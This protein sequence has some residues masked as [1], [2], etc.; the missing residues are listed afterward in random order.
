MENNYNYTNQPA[1]PQPN[2]APQNNNFNATVNNL[3]EKGKVLAE[4]G[5]GLAEKGINIF[6]SNPK[7]YG[8]LCG[9]ILTGVIVFI[10]VI[11]LVLGAL[12]NNYKTPVKLM[13]KNRNSKSFSSYMDRSIDMLNGFCKSEM[14]AILKVYK[15]SDDY[16]DDMEDAKDEFADQIEDMKDEYGSN[17]KYTYTITDKERLEKEDLKKFRDELRNAADSLEAQIDEADDYD[18]DDWEDIADDAGISKAQAKKL[19]NAMDDVRK[20]LKKAQVT[21]GY[22]LEVTIAL[23]GSELD[24]PEEN[25]MTI[26]VYKVDG[27]WISS[28]AMSGISLF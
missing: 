15:S 3:T 16:K 2:P 24:E 1:N 23:T 14:K 4:K 20:V 18:S 25:E 27:R 28:S 19:Y 22:E 13:E 5:K 6:K 11:S 17:Y 8:I 7:K 9:G 26:R 10:V 21:D 12:F